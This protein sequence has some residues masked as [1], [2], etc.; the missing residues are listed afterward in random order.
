M[1]RIPATPLSATRLENTKYAEGCTGSM[2]MRGAAGRN[3]TGGYE[4]IGD[5]AIMTGGNSR[6]PAIGEQGALLLAAHHNVRTVLL[7]KGPGRDRARVP[8]YELVAGVAGTVTTHREYG[9][10]YRLDLSRIFFSGKLA[11]ERQRVAGL[12]RPGERVMVP[13]AGAGPFVV[14]AAA[15]GAR[16]TAVERNPEACRYLRENLERNSV[17]GSVLV[18]EGDVFGSSLPG[19][20]DRVIVPAPYSS[21]PE[22]VPF[23]RWVRPGGMI[24]FYLFA[25]R[26]QIPALSREFSRLGLFTLMVRRCGNVAP[27]VNRWVFD[28]E[29]C[30]PAPDSPSG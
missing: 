25:G 9:F 13:F 4:I 19:Q 18:I 30:R 12:V 7:R 26:R 11:S 14:P 10:S 3:I 15:R 29:F 22:P 21:R 16:V 27:S 17:G 2:R 1:S 20:F 5:I 28:L 6:D 8:E 24:H 23:L